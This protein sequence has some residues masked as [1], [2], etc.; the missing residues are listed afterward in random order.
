IS[1]KSITLSIKFLFIIRYL[2][3]NKVKFYFYRLEALPIFVKKIIFNFEYYA[4][5]DIMEAFP[6]FV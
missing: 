3:S 2:F 4:Y 6:I 1:I 5:Y